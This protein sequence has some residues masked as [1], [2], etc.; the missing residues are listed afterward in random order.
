M[1]CQSEEGFVALRTNVLEMEM[2]YRCNT[3][4]QYTM[5]QKSTRGLLFLLSLIYTL[6][7][8][9]QVIGV[10]SFFDTK[11]MPDLTKILAN[12]PSE[13]TDAFIYDIKRYMWG[14]KQRE[15]SVRK[16]IAIRDGKYGVET[17]AREF[18]VPFGI[19]ISRENTPII[20]KLLEEALSTCDSISAQPKD[21][22]HRTR[23]FVYFC[24]S[25]LIPKDETALKTN[26]SYPSGHTIMGYSAALLLTEINPNRADT[27]MA[28]GIMFG[29]SRV[30]VGAHWQ[31]DVDAGRLAASIAYAKL[32]TSKR[33]LR[34]M[35]KARKEFAR[36]KNKYTVN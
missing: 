14:K 25:T 22:W 19:S 33:F 23:P 20:Y 7:T 21:Y 2:R 30:I 28:R 11:A 18:S 35:R 3:N 8:N 15:D 24:E 36:K 6:F 32:H 12:P 16:A 31:S 34:Q 26:G 17:I 13:G 4:N 1:E 10:R 29:D 27:L 9:A 5:K